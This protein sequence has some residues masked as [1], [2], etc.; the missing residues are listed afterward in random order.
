MFKRLHVWGCV[1][2][3]LLCLLAGFYEHFWNWFEWGIIIRS[4]A[5]ENKKNEKKNNCG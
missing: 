5:S 2:R 3:V 1:C 4:R